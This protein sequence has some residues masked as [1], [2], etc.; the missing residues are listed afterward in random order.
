MKK[1]ITIVDYGMGNLL[2]V[3]RAFEHFAAETET[4]ADPDKVSGADYLVLPGVGAFAD[5]MAELRRRN[6][7]DAFRDHAQS[8]RPSLSICLGMQ[9]LLAESREFGNHSGLGIIDGAV[10]EIPLTG[11][12]GSSHKV[13]HIGWSQLNLPEGAD[14]GLWRRTILDGIVPG[15]SVYFVHSFTAD[16]S[17]P[18]SRL[19][20]ADYNGRLVSAAVRRDNVFGTQFHPEKSGPVGLRIV[21]NFLYLG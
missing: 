1:R 12:D 5:G 18:A 4:T 17:D 21:E 3:R 10:V 16:P 9:M 19:A 8:G 6:L 2:S 15:V 13:P 7:I 20:D 14:G 11:A